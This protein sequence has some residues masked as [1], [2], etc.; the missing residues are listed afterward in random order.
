MSGATAEF[1]ATGSTESPLD[2]D[3]AVRRG[4]AQRCRSR[5][6]VAASARGTSVTPSRTSPLAICQVLVIAR[7]ALHRDVPRG[8]RIPAGFGNSSAALAAASRARG[9]PV[10]LWYSIRPQVVASDSWNDERRVARGCSSNRHR[11]T[12]THRASA[13]VARFGGRWQS[14]VERRP[15]GVPEH[16]CIARTGPSTT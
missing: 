11:A 6:R 4:A 2:P 12:A 10:A 13:P 5:G 1:S 15:Q 8:R 9:S 16:G 3:D 7:I 14:R